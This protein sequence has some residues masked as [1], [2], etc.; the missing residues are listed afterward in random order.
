MLAIILKSNANIETIKTYILNLE[1]KFSSFAFF[2]IGEIDIIYILFYSQE[3]K[4][5]KSRK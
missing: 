5:R 2:V 3:S 1:Q 4:S